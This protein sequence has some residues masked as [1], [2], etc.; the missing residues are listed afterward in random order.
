MWISY[1]FYF[2]WI[3][4]LNVQHWDVDLRGNCIPYQKITFFFVLYLKIINTF[5]E[6]NICILKKIA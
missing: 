4:K 3:Q 6:N 5:L 2:Q 1:K